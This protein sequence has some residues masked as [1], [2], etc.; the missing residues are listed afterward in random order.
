MTRKRLKFTDL[1]EETLARV[2]KME[3]AMDSVILVMEPH[4]DLAVLTDE[5]LAR[6]QALEKELNVWLLAFASKE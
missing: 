2:K 5:Q 6:I 1:D 3:E 4:I